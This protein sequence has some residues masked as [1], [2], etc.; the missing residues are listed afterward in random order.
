MAHTAKRTLAAI[1]SI[2]LALGCLFAIPFGA[3]AATT[4]QFALEATTEYSAGKATGVV[5]SVKAKSCVG[6]KSGKFVITYDSKVLKYSEGDAGKDALEVS[7]KCNPDKNT[8]NIAINSG[9]AGK[10]HLGCFFL[11]KLMSKADFEKC[12]TRSASSIDVNSENFEIAKFYFDIK[13]T[14]A[15]STSFKITMN[16]STYTT[17]GC[18]AKLVCAHE[19]YTTVTTKKA[20]FTA[21]GKR[22]T[23]CAVCG[24]VKSTS[25]LAKIDADSVKLSYTKTTYSGSA[26][27]PSVTVKNTSGKLLTKDTDYTVTYSSNTNPGKASVKITFKGKYS[28]TKTL[29]FGIKPKNVTDLKAGSQTTSSVKLSWTKAAGVTG[30]RVYKYSS[31]TKKYTKI[32]STSNTYYTVKDLKAGT[33]YTYYVKAYKTVDGKAILSASYTSVK[34]GTKTKAPAAPVLTPGTGKITVKWTKVTGAT[35]YELRMA[36]SKSGTYDKITST[37]KLTYTKTSLKA[38]KTVYFK[39]RAYKTVDGKKIWSAY[40]PIVSG[41]AK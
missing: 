13:D 18:T 21:T 19:K 27:K 7:N 1:L 22:S 9:S 24:K 26:K 34:T 14:T 10:I 15:T 31:S 28:G 8:F 29:T 16:S 23:Q 36:S 33:A 40:S 17:A 38:G 12:L 3:S 5:L 41:K 25:T 2:V 32:A 30:Y 4:K 35:G 37:T 20:T 39:V 11:E 6:F